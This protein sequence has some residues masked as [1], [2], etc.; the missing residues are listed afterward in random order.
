M[1]N[2]KLL[3]ANLLKGLLAFF[4]ALALF[5]L[6]PQLASAQTSCLP[7]A[8]SC[9][10]GDLPALTI[11][12]VTDVQGPCTDLIP[13]NGAGVLEIKLDISYRFN[14]G[15][16]T[17]YD[18]GFFLARDGQDVRVTADCAVDYLKPPLTATRPLTEYNIWPN[19]SGEFWDAE[20]TPGLVDECGDVGKYDTASR[21][22]NDVTVTCVD[23]NGNG[24]IDVSICQVYDNNQQN[25]CGAT[26]PGTGSKC[27]CVRM[28]LPI[29]PTAI[30]GLSFSASSQALPVGLALGGVGLVLIAGVLLSVYLRRRVSG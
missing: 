18:L 2:T 4:F 14:A 30:E 17:R 3:Q 5:A 7:S 8:G 19:A 9:T 6:T 12:S 28:D 20:D 10:A 25:D 16:N 15:A 1:E 23:T 13:T 21:T 24:Q 22:L 11:T 29:T 26:N 27:D